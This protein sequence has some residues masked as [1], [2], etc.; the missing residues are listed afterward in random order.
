MDWREAIFGCGTAFVPW[1][2]DGKQPVPG[3]LALS[4]PDQHLQLQVRAVI[5][6]ELQ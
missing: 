2:L 1:K 3:R 5:E 4:P 6:G